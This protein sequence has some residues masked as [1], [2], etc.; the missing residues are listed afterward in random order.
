M[1]GVEPSCCMCGG[2]HVCMYVCLDIPS[3]ALLHVA[4]HQE[5]FSWWDNSILSTSCL[6]IGTIRPANITA[7][8]SVV[9]CHTSLL[10]EK[11]PSNCLLIIH[12]FHIHSCLALPMVFVWPRG[13]TDLSNKELTIKD[14]IFTS[15]DI[16]TCIMIIIIIQGW[17]SWRHASY[18][19][20]F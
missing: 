14:S 1:R 10:S 11:A 9:I 15:E 6:A 4:L 13:E 5:R 20:T 7:L 12:C 16:K 8:Y 19:Y 17:V 18:S 2:L 3:L